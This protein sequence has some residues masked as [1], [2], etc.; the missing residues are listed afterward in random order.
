MLLNCHLFSRTRSLELLYKV[1]WK[2]FTD[3]VTANHLKESEG[4]QHGHILGK[5]PKKKKKSKNFEVK[6]I[7]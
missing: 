4:I 1:N 7:K 3:P 5:M 2:M 6:L